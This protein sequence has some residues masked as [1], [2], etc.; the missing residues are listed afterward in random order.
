MTYRAPETNDS[1]PLAQQIEQ[2]IDELPGDQ[3]SVGTLLSALGDEGLLLMVILLSAIFII[4]VSIPGL[5]T[6]FGASI[7]LIG[8]SRVRNRP[9]R[10]P[11]KL[12]RREIATDKLKTNLG[13]A[14]KWVHRMERLSRPMRL[15]VMVRSKKM[16]RLNNLMLVFATLL[17]M[18]PAGPI[19]FSNTLPALALMSFAIG[20]IQRDGA[21]V[22]AGYGFV[23]A[24]VVYFG[25]L[26]G[27]VGLAAE[28]VFSGFRSGTAEL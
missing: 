20:F 22:A 26:L 5:S 23:V 12:A 19:P 10:V 27:G 8:L 18:A 13:R 6:V 28:S 14:L 3:V 16:M 2:M 4:P 17:L 7:L 11:Q 1:A 25:V 21:A 9:L 15:A 24:T